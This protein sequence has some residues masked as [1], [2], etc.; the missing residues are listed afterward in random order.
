MTPQHDFPDESLQTVGLRG[1]KQTGKVTHPQN[2]ST[3]VFLEGADHFEADRVVL[4]FSPIDVST[5]TTIDRMRFLSD[6]F[7]HIALWVNLSGLRKLEQQT[8]YV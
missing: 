4:V 2:Q 6:P 3:P 8:K 7:E 1:E 5:T